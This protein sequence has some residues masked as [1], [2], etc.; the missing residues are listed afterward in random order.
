MNFRI[1][2]GCCSC[3]VFRS[4]Q[5]LL[6]LVD[7]EAI[8]PWFEA[9]GIKSVRKESGDRLAKMDFQISFLTELKVCV[10]RYLNDFSP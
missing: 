8:F 4:R 3:G 6:A 1:S 2:F 5:G 7:P 10:L 9:S